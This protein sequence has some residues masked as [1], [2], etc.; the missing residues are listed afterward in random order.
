MS[1][2]L[3]IYCDL[4]NISGDNWLKITS[5]AWRAAILNTR[6]SSYIS[7]HTN[8]LVL[9]LG[10]MTT[11]EDHL[12]NPDLTLLDNKTKFHHIYLEYKDAGVEYIKGGN[13]VE[14]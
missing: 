4:W 7:T 6:Q 10:W 1:Q 3:W 14:T 8:E 2:E 13:V 12:R 5:S 9:V 11:K